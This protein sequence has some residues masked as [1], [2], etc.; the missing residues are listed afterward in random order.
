M[1]NRRKISSDIETQV[2]VLSRRRCALCF[3]LKEI[4]EEQKGQIAHLDQDPSNNSLDNLVFLCLNHH[5]AYDSSTSQSKGYTESELKHYRDELY[6][7]FR[8]KGATSGKTRDSRR[9]KK[10]FATEEELKY[11]WDDAYF[12]V[13][14]G[15]VPT[16]DIIPELL[17]MYSYEYD[18][19]VIRPIVTIIANG[20]L[21]QHMKQQASWPQTTDCDRLDVAFAELESKGIICRQDFADCTTCG[22]AEIQGEIKKVK[23]TG[24]MVRGFTFYHQQ[25]TEGA[26]RNGG[27]HLGYGSLVDD[28][29]SDLAIATEVADTLRRHGLRVKWENNIKWRIEVELD[30]KRRR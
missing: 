4:Q 10:R 23:R 22:Y 24:K 21:E 29:K 3:A 1:A 25:D 13:E 27:I 18:L 6:S 28:E 14:A 8:P 2:L 7:T 16:D 15:L 30:W 26:V 5:D 11:I 20:L 12:L 17:A 9:R 19:R